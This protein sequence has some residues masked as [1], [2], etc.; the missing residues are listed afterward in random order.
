[1]AGPVR[2][3]CFCIPMVHHTLKDAIR[4][5]SVRCFKAKVKNVVR[6][7]VQIRKNTGIWCSSTP[8]TVPL[9]VA[10][11]LKNYGS[12]LIFNVRWRRHAKFT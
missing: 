6:V 10:K 9:R 2:T 11:K 4:C 8:Q 12:G 7:Y 5:D 3:V 1:M